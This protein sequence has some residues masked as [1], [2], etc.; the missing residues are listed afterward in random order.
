M[1][2]NVTINR[3]V[4]E[5]KGTTVGT[6]ASLWRTSTWLTT[7]D[8][9]RLHDSTAGFLTYQIGDYVVVGGMPVSN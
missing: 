6:T 9:A 8:R 5:G 7:R 4:G 3:A 2:V 1:S